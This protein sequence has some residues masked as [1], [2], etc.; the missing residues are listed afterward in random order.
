MA[1]VLITQCLQR[2]GG[3]GSVRFAC[4]HAKTDFDERFELLIRI[5]ID[6]AGRTGKAVMTGF[7][8]PQPG[9]GETESVNAPPPLPGLQLPEQDYSWRSTAG[10]ESRLPS[11]RNQSFG[12]RGPGGGPVRLKAP[13]WASGPGRPGGGGISEN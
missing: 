5:F 12:R 3:A 10:P 9:N 4:R 1:T 11:H 6:G 7:D 13:T 8:T 2:E